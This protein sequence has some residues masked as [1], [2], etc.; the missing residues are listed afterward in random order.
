MG[1][2]LSSVVQ[3]ISAPC[4]HRCGVLPFL[5]S[6]ARSPIP[7]PWVMHASL[8]VSPARLPSH[9]SQH[10]LPSS[11]S[12]DSCPLKGSAAGF[13]GLPPNLSSWLPEEGSVHCSWWVG[14]QAEEVGRFSRWMDEHKEVKTEGSAQDPQNAYM[15]AAPNLAELLNCG[16]YSSLV[17]INSKLKMLINGN[18][19]ADF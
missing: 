10:A 7:I 2:N 13:S 11:A 17:N 4:L 8:P 18:S 16:S 3:P 12:S 1:T 6:S 15:S 5:A 19:N 14:S 9:H